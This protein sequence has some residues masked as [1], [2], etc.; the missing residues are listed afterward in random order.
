MLGESSSVGFAL[1][2]WGCVVSGILAVLWQKKVAAVESVKFDY[3]S[4]ALCGA[5]IKGKLKGI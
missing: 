5:V 1:R 4:M 2:C 3:L